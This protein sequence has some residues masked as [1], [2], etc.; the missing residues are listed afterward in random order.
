MID[1][2]ASLLGQGL[3]PAVVSTAVGCTPSYISQLLSDPDFAK[4]V[5]EIRMIDLTRD[6]SIDEI[7]DDVEERLLKKFQTSIDFYTKPKDILDAL[8]KINAAKRKTKL[9]AGAANFQT[10]TVVQITLPAIT[11]NQYKINIA[12]KMTEV[13]GRT[14]KPMSSQNLMKTLEERRSNGQEPKLLAGVLEA[15]SRKA[16]EITID[17]I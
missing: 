4:R 8:T 2:I 12:G 1:K 14:L 9:D 6:K 7:W 3:S 13:E 15:A 16:R 17:S 11:I 5:T 10:G